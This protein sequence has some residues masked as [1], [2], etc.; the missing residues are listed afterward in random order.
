MSNDQ[1]FRLSR[2]YAKGWNAAKA[3]SSDNLLDLDA[4]KIAAMNPY[5]QEDERLRWAEGFAGGAQK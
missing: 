5:R 2:I 4:E 3:L 1:S